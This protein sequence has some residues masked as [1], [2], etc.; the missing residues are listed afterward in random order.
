MASIKFTLYYLFKKIDNILFRNELNR[1]Y[2]YHNYSI[3]LHNDRQK[4]NN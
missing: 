3:I 2:I 1:I 4:E